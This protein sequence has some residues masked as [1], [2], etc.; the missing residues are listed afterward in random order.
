MQIFLFFTV[1]K[2]FAAL[3]RLLSTAAAR[4]LTGAYFFAA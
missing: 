4:L 1:E 3:P 2:R